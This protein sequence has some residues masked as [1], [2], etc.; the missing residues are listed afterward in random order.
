MQARISTLTLSDGASSA[1]NGLPGLSPYGTGSSQTQFNPLSQPWGPPGQGFPAEYQKEMYP[2]TSLGYERRHSVAD[3]GSSAGSV[4]RAGQLNS[5]RS[6]AGTPQAP[7]DPWSRPGSRD[8]RNGPELERRGPIPASMHQQPAPYFNPSYYSGG[9]QQPYPPHPLYDSFGTGFR[10]SVT[11]PYSM[12]LNPYL[13]SGIPP[14]RPSKDQDPA[15]GM[16]SALLDEFRSTSKSNKRFE[17]KHIYG[18][19]VEFSGDQHGSRFIQE[20]LETANSD[21]KDQVFREI[22]P[23]AVQLMKDVFGNYVIQKS[24]SMEIKFRRRCWQA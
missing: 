16:R 18:H 13:T 19:I 9:Y 23:N 14:M 10:S 3:R 21:E 15:R 17:L 2:S 1:S 11:M 12:P 8:P 22:E 4:Y 20:K 5:P 24:L 7:S 6:F